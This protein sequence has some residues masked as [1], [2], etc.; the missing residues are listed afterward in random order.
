MNRLT[1]G[2]FQDR[3]EAVARARGIFGKLTDGN[4]TEAFALY[5]GVL[6][7]QDRD[8]MISTLLSGNRPPA[9][10]DQFE[11]PKCPEC[12]ADLM[13]KPLSENAEGY[14]VLLSCENPNCKTVLY[15]EMSIEEWA[16]ELQDAGRPEQVETGQ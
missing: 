4:I 9:L 14:K 5:Q 6:A 11:R 12:G 10:F 1:R 8:V 16:K 3:V 7:E 15:S 13:F 2:E